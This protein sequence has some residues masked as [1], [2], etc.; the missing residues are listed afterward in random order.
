MWAVK[1]SE[2]NGQGSRGWSREMSQRVQEPANSQAESDG[3]IYHAFSLREVGMFL[4]GCQK[5][6]DL[7]FYE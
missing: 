3:C 5:V 6:C 4:P 2:Q 1:R 7:L